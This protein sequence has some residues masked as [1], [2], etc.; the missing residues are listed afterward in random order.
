MLVYGRS[1]QEQINE[2]LTKIGPNIVLVDTI[3]MVQYI[4]SGYSAQSRTILYLDDLYSVRYQRTLEAMA[5]FPDAAIDAVGTFNRFLPKPVRGMVRGRE[6]QRML[7]SR[8]SAILHRRETE[9]PK[10]FDRVLLLNRNEAAQLAAETSADN[11]VVVKPLMKRNGNLR[12]RRFNG[13]PVFVFVGNLGYSPNPYSLSLFL[14]R[15]MPGLLE[16]VPRSKLLIVGKGAAP[17]LKRQ[18]G[19]FA[20]SVEF[21]DFV[22]DLSKLFSEV[23]AM[24][25][26]LVFGTGLKIKSLEA[27]SSGLPMVATPCG[28]EGLSVTDGR[29]CFVVSNLDGFV[30]PMVRLLDLELNHNMSQNALRFYNENFSTSRVTAEYAKLFFATPDDRY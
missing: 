9:M 10:Q 28:V 1:T 2:L 21:L 20:G 19:R 15:T 6:L 22:P 23:A 4:S 24:V 25:V 11:V 8:E 5:K 27:L 30:S 14:T 7:L 29:E 18:A 3:R 26:P 16:A 12:A 17:D 13:E